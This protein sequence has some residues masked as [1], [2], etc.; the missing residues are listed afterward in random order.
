MNPAQH[1]ELVERLCSNPELVDDVGVPILIHKDDQATVAPLWLKKPEQIRHD[2]LS[3]NLVGWVAEMWGYTMAAGELGLRHTK[4]EL[5]RVQM[6]DRADLPIVHY[7][8]SSS[9]VG[10]RWTW[11]KRTYRPWERVADP[12]AETPLAS[13][14]LI[15][16]LNE[17]VA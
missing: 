7:A 4:R 11:D 3:R 9:D 5:Q 2:S 1:A 15:D 10:K 8:Y 16:L 12:P 17:W 13:R 14:V 6:E